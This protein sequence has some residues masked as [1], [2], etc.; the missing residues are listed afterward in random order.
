LTITQYR[1]DASRKFDDVKAVLRSMTGTAKNKPDITL[2]HE[3]IGLKHSHHNY[4]YEIPVVHPNCVAS[5]S[6]ES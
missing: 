5:V 2:A 1:E 3:A 4:T 6:H